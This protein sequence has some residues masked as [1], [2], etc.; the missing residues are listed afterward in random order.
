MPAGDNDEDDEEDEEDEDDEEEISVNIPELLHHHNTG[1]N[2]S[3]RADHV[4]ERVG[5]QEINIS[6]LKPK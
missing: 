6:M 2:C 3:C 4:N 5:I 1:F